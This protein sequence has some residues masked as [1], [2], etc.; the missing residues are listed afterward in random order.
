M[1]F[2]ASESNLRINVKTSLQ[3]CLAPLHFSVSH[4]FES[5]QLK[6]NTRTAKNLPRHFDWI[7]RTWDRYSRDRCCSSFRSK[8]KFRKNLFLENKNWGQI[9]ER[10]I[11]LN[12]KQKGSDHSC[13]LEPHELKT[14]IEHIRSV[15]LALGSPI[16][17][18]QEC[19]T[20]CFH[21]LGKC[22]V[23]SRDLDKGHRLSPA[24]FKVKVSL[25]KGLNPF[26]YHQVDGKCLVCSV[27]ADDPLQLS[28]F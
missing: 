25:I 13:S 6:S 3:L 1:Q 21:K 22:L 2:S 4:T 15:E 24:D 20:A 12:K 7:F 17:G 9:V 16:K 26:E 14:M 8:S 28:H 18:M 11:T 23:Y 5:N 10:H 27:N 19:E